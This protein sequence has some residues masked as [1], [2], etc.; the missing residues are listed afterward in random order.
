MFCS[1]LVEAGYFQ[2]V[3]VGFLI[4]GH[5]HASI[6]QYFSCLRRKIRNASFIASPMALQHLFLLPFSASERK[7]SRF[8]KPLSQLQLYF[9]HDYRSALAPYYNPAI[10]SFNIPYQ[11][12]F[13]NVLSKCVSQHKQF[14]DSK[15]PWLPLQSSE[16]LKTVDQ[17][18]KA[19]VFS[20]ENTHSLSTENGKSILA[21][22]MGFRD[23]VD[24]S[25]LGYS[26]TGEELEKFTAF[27]DILPEL[28]QIESYA[29]AEQV[30][31]HEDEASGI[32]DIERYDEVEVRDAQKSNQEALQSLNTK[33]HG[34][35]IINLLK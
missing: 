9:V 4:V 24:T 34:N 31:R 12:K 26:S 25:R 29:L 3:T 28:Q 2:T 18:Y 19:R 22:H 33:T 1:I 17:L 27:N 13:F 20:I 21:D 14:A 30:L 23:K 16:V 35:G 15:L 11:F 7:K 6:D 8:R 5:T 32:N 10:T